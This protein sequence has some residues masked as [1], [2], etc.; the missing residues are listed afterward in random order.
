MAREYTYQYTI[1]KEVYADNKNHARHLAEKDLREKHY[2]S[3][4]KDKIEIIP[5]WK[6]K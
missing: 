6:H 2:W 5:T 3:A 4:D 1:I